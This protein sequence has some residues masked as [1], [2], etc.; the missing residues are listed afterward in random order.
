MQAEASMRWIAE[1]VQELGLTLNTD[2]IHSGHIRE[3]FDFVGYTFREGISPKSGKLVR[4]KMPRKQ[5][6]K[7]IRRNLKEKLKGECL[8]KTL[9]ELIP[10]L[11]RSIRGWAQYFRSGQCYQ[12]LLELH[13]YVCEQLRIFMRR[14]H[15][16]KRSRGYN[17]WSNT[18]FC[19]KGLVYA[20]NL[21]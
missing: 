19:R 6:C 10:M 4:V 3:G 14:R 2:K 15:S 12:A 8:G 17:R 11:N 21:R 1:V 18:F 13:G 7:S 20:P 16:T 9:D 5:S